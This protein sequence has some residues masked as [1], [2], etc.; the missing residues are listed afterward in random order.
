M[1]SGWGGCGGLRSLVYRRVTFRVPEPLAV[2]VSEVAKFSGWQPAD[3]QRT[4]ICIGATFFI[5]SYGNEAN[6]DAATK[7]LGG[8]KL[9]SLTRGFGLGFSRRPYAFRQAYRKSTVA[10]VSLPGSVCEVITAH[11]GLRHASR[12]QVYNRCLHQGLLVYLKVHATA[13]G[14]AGRSPL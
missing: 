3:L 12:N 7:L 5:L 10:T 9:L 1:G 2:Q 13:L 8:M 4:L 6:E 14:T 11:A